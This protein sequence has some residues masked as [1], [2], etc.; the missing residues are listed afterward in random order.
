MTI[1]IPPPHAYS[2]YFYPLM[3]FTFP[4]EEKLKREKQIREVFDKGA[5]I[6]VFPL[7]LLYLKTEDKIFKFQAGFTV[8]KRNFRRA[9]ERNR[10]KRLLREVYRLNK[11][12]IFNKT[13]GSYAFMF[14][15]LGKELPAFHDLE[16]TM[17]KLLN[18]FISR[19]DDEKVDP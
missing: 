10:I 16:E 19:V 18:K 1:V 3:R 5:P 15:Y 6:T 2:C 13:E 7:K 8:P 11:P 4:K 14:L 9:V 12:H 17:R